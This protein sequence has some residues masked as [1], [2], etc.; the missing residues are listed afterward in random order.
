MPLTNE[1]DVQVT[2]EEI[3]RGGMPDWLTSHL[4]TQSIGPVD[5]SESLS[6]I[7]IIYP[8]ES[9]RRQTLSE[10]LATLSLIHI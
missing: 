2:S 1:S 9:S 10:I 4:T 8:T 3:P 5:D 7:L 6:R